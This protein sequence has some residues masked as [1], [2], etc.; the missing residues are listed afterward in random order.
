MCPEADV[1]GQ[2]NPDS[3]ITRQAI[4]TFFGKHSLNNDIFQLYQSHGWLDGP[5]A[6]NFQS[7]FL[8]YIT[9]SVNQFSCFVVSRTYGCSSVDTITKYHRP[10]TS[11]VLVPRALMDIFMFEHW[12]HC[13]K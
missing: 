13:V 4:S 2:L 6:H 11:G 3:M 10:V 7:V 12:V 8:I 1:A 9:L 5:C